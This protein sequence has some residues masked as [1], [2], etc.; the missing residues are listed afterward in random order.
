MSLNPEKLEVVEVIDPVLNLEHK[1][2]YGAIDAGKEI[3]YAKFDSQST[4]NNSQVNII[5]NPSSKDVVIH[6]QAYLRSVITMA[7]TGTG[8]ANL[9]TE[10]YGINAALRAFPINNITQTLTGTFNNTA[11]TTNISEYISAV[12]RYNN[13]WTNFDREF[14]TCPS[15]LDQS[16]TYAEL[17]GEPRNP[18]GKY[19]DNVNIMPRGGYISYVVNSFSATAANVTFTVT[20]P[21][22]ISPLYHSKAGITGIETLQIQAVFS[23]INRVWSQS[24]TSNITSAVATIGTVS[25]LFRYITPKLTEMIPKQLTYP[26]HSIQI[27]SQNSNGTMVQGVAGSQQITVNATNLS[28]IPARILVCARKN[29]S[30]LGINDPDVFGNISNISV[31]FGN[32]NGLLSSAQPEDLFQMSRIAGLNINYTQWLQ[33]CGSVLCLDVAKVI[34]L[35]ELRSAGSLDNIQFSIQAQVTNTSSLTQ[36]MTLYAFVIYEGIFGVDNGNVYQNI[37]PL[38]KKDV[39]GAELN[40]KEVV[41]HEARNFY[42]GDFFDDLKEGVQKVLPYVE[43]GLNIARIIGGKKKK[44]ASKKK[45]PFCMDMKKKKKKVVKRKGRA[46]LGGDLVDRKDLLNN[47]QDLD[48]E[49]ED[50][51]ESEYES[52]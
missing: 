50:D 46:L 40:H 45:D 48:L 7:L 3:R 30:N 41:G 32:R 29:T 24:T 52:E 39:L 1:R 33:Y 47:L 35:D 38:S 25:V 34:G 8:S 22:F 2:R 18:L 44:K 36:N 20:E 51:S 27:L 17:I 43:T 10:N 23:N 12:L 11:V 14:S 28:A 49:S 16:Q 4:T 31:Q 42:G 5:C 21:L 37:A 19:G 13:E 6:P 26:F 15:M 9:F